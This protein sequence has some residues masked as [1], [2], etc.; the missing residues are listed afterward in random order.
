MVTTG[1]AVIL[2]I[3]G[4]IIFYKFLKSLWKTSK[5]NEWL[6]VIRNGKLS[7][8]GIGLC[9]WT[10]PFDQIVVFPSLIN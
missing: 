8:S 10:S 3:I 2:L 4:S 5:A 7:K 9:T 6:L 1:V